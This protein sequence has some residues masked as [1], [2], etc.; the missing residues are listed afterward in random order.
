MKIY[1]NTFLRWF[2]LLKKKSD[3]YRI[4]TGH[5]IA[6]DIWRDLSNNFEDICLEN[7]S[8]I[9]P[10][11][12]RLKLQNLYFQKTLS[13]T[14]RKRQEKENESN[15]ENERNLQPIDAGEIISILGIGQNN[16]EGLR[17]S[18]QRIRKEN[19]GNSL[20]FI[21]QNGVIYFFSLFNQEFQ[22][23]LP[24]IMRFESIEC[25]T[26]DSEFNSQNGYHGPPGR[27]T[28]FIFHYITTESERMTQKHFCLGNI[29]SSGGCHL[30]H[31]KV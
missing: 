21:H 18:I 27:G 23:I 7:D 1:F 31:F 25:V 17:K 15:S 16:F 29:C 14:K 22:K 2:R 6:I 10:S 19:Q 26:I 9:A 13:G 12:L 20:S 11:N 3:G 4:E 30:K 8:P 28:A 24:T 5:Y